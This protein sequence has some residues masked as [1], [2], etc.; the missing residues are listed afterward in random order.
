MLARRP[1]PEVGVDDEDART[2][3]A[4]V[5]ER[6]ARVRG[7][8][9]FKQMLLE[10]VERN[11]AQ[12]PCRHDAVGVDVVAAKRQTAA[13]DFEDRTRRRSVCLLDRHQ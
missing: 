13:R 8:I 4:R 1:G 6:V 7:T 12:E 9:V 11:G 5:A 10:A 3:V 2:D